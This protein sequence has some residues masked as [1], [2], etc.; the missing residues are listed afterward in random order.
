MRRFGLPT[1]LQHLSHSM[2]GRDSCGKGNGCVDCEER[3]DEKEAFVKQI[4][5]MLRDEWM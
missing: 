3:Q 5:L 4:Y 1:T 2:W